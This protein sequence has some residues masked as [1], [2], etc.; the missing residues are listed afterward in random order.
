MNHSLGDALDRAAG[1]V[2]ELGD[3]DRAVRVVRTR[4]IRI[5]VGTLTTLSLVLLLALWLGG[6][7]APTSM[8]PVG[9]RPTPQVDEPVAGAVPVWYDAKGLHHGNVVEQTPVD[10][11][12]Q[13][14]ALGPMGALALVRSGALYWDPATLEVWFH[15][16]GASPTSWDMT[17]PWVL[18]GTRTGTR[19]RGSRCQGPPA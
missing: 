14:G 17:R 15:P 2:G 3:I 11:A 13:D 5:A 7:P 9:P 6:M 10:I 12:A 18:A 1:D 19:P 16:W 4:R 8:E